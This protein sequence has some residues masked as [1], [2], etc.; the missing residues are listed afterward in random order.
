MNAEESLSEK[1]TGNIMLG[2]DIDIWPKKENKINR[3]K[4]T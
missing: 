3:K 4:K 2:R 1:C